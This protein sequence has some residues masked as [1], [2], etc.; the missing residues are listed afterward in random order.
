MKPIG[1]EDSLSHICLPWIKHIDSLIRSMS[2]D[3]LPHE[4]FPVSYPIIARSIGYVYFSNTQYQNSKQFLSEFMVY[5]CHDFNDSGDALD[6]R[7]AVFYSLGVSFFKTGEL[8]KAKNL[9][10]D[11]Y[12]IA[13]DLK[14]ER[15]SEALRIQ[16]HLS[17]TS[18][19]IQRYSRY[20]ATAVAAA[21]GEKLSAGTNIFEE[22][23]P[24]RRYSIGSS[25]LQLD[26]ETVTVLEGSVHANCNERG[27]PSRPTG[28]APLAEALRDGTLE[29][30]HIFLKRGIFI[31]A[32]DVNGRGPLHWASSNG[33]IAELQ[34]LLEMASELDVLDHY[35]YT[36]LYLAIHNGFYRAAK[37]LLDHGA[38]PIKG[39]DPGSTPLEVAITEARVDVILL[40]VDKFVGLTFLDEAFDDSTILI[41]ASRNG[42]TG[43]V[44]SLLGR[45]IDPDVGDSRELRPLHYASFWGH[46][47][48]VSLL[49]KSG[50]NPNLTDKLGWTALTWIILDPVSFIKKNYETNAIGDKYQT[51]SD[52][53]CKKVRAKIARILLNYGANPDIEDERGMS[54]LRLAIQQKSP[55][56]WHLSIKKLGRLLRA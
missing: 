19:R 16:E 17:R 35:G 23:V 24:S 41:W 31:E 43:L 21:R 40:L 6:E 3:S 34:I 39:G 2:K 33:Y 56:A 50:A 53:P 18:K 5:N 55:I 37:L 14:G 22:A 12:S 10:K 7:L 13:K 9:L 11:A 54:T 26:A 49:L 44:Q 52:L 45:G 25:G 27:K 48:T 36:P 29:S 1:V 32:P 38:N 46:I 51:E 8:D 15:S 4:R 30:A 20:H 42:Y 47:D 28:A